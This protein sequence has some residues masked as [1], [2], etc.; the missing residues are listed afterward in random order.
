M[1]AHGSTGR[2]SYESPARRG[3]RGILVRVD[4]A[5]HDAFRQLASELNSSVDYLGHKAI[6][7][8]FEHAGAHIPDGLRERL[9]APAKQR[10]GRPPKHTETPSPVRSRSE[11]Y[12][13]G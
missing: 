3:K 6:A 11:K 8:L 5:T 1:N 13:P 9:Q 7:L 2:K 12:T 10:T 4:P